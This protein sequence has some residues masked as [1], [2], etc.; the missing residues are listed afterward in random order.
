MRP[1]FSSFVVFWKWYK[2]RSGGK[3]TNAL[4]KCLGAS[5]SFL[6]SLPFC[7]SQPLILDSDFCSI[8]TCCFFNFW[9]WILPVFSFFWLD[10]LLV[11]TACLL[12]RF[13]FGLPRILFAGILTL[14]L[15]FHSGLSLIYLHCVRIRRIPG[16]VCFLSFVYGLSSSDGVYYFLSRLSCV[17]VVLSHAHSW[18]LI[19]TL[20]SFPGL[21]WFPALPWFTSCLLFPACTS[22]T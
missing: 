5:V 1:R 10:C 12:H 13:W 9:F 14:F 15:D 6:T 17:Y 20:L 4:D 16:H 8:L 7:E 21:V 3:L 19:V 22:F 2:P 18:S 11:L